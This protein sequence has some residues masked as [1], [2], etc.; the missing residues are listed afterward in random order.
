MERTVKGLIYGLLVISSINTLQ[1]RDFYVAKDGDDS[2]SGAIDA[3]FLTLQ[4][5]AEIAEA[6]DTVFIREGFYEEVLSPVN[7]G[8]AGKPIIFQ[9]YPDEKVVITAMQSL[10][11]WQHDKGDVYVTQ[12]DW[13]LGQQNFVM[14]GNTAMDLARW[15]NN[16]DGD[17][18]TQNSLRNTGGSGPNVINNAY[19][20]YADGI[21][22]GDWSKGGSIYFY[23]DKPGSGWTSWRAFIT[24]N[25]ATRVTFELDKN[26]AWIR[27]FHAPADKGD[28]FLQG[29][30]E[31]LDY[32]NEWY[33]DPETKKL[34]VQLPNGDKPDDH[35][36]SMRKRTKTIDLEGKSYIHI[37]NLAVFGG[38]IEITKGASYNHI[39]GVTSLYGNYTLGVVSGF[40]SGNQS[41]NI[42]S[43]WNQFN[44]K[45][46]IIEKSEIGFGSGTGIYDSG[47]HTQIL[48]S[49]L[50]DFNYL[51][52]YDAIINARGGNHTKVFNNTIT[53][54]GRDAIQGF[55]DHAEYAYN[56]VSRSNLIADDCGLFYTVGGPSHTEIHH[57]WFHDAYSSGNKNKAAGIYLDNDAE[58][59]LVHHNVI[60]NT[61]WSSIQINW[62][63]TDID[64]FNNTMFNAS[65]VMGAWHKEGTAFSD[66]RVWNNIS[67]SSAWEPQSDKQNNITVTSNAFI[68]PQEG[69][70]RLAANA[71]PIDSGRQITEIQADVIDGKPDA[72]AYEI[73]GENANWVAGITWEQKLGP[74]GNGCYGLPG[75]NCVAPNL[76]EPSVNFSQDQTVEEGKTASVKVTLSHLAVKYPVTIPYIISGSA[77]SSDHNAQ[78]GELRINSGQQGSILIEI[79]A[80]EIVNEEETLILT[81]GNPINAVSGAKTTHSII[82]KDTTPD[83]PQ[84]PTIGEPPTDSEQSSG[85]AI[86]FTWLLLIGFNAYLRRRV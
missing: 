69:D 62:N 59:F 72:G 44:S 52:N 48:D 64:I 42:R 28:F 75:E 7:S 25:T 34:Y 70:F 38:S 14:Q 26:P 68:A 6:G 9:S 10:T 8:E 84:P 16:I 35:Q 33:F 80:D 83:L 41:V 66:V 54:A 81:M 71:T 61:E 37:K 2:H 78:N 55:N 57:N 65:A 24:G 15:P 47:E 12:V 85:G 23:G 79:K 36:V 40:A 67:D 30:R 20:D 32:Q 13:D 17:P 39:Y 18:F 51:G 49:Y 4:K 43:D 58:S 82:I 19:L 46:N 53:R 5:A 31:V 11:G 29:I 27:T 50:H 3:P 1:A 60:W 73:G 45:Y 76:T 63:G 56:D 74:T 21:P 77:G 22:S 86:G